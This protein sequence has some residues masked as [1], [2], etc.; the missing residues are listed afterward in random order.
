MANIADIEVSIQ[1]VKINDDMAIGIVRGDC[2]RMDAVVIV[3]R[4][5][6]GEGPI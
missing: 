2:P 4:E 5:D 3:Q 6:E 1:A